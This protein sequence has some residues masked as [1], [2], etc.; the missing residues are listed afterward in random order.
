M[1]IPQSFIQDLLTRADIVDVVGKH[2]QLKKGGSNFMGLCPFHGEK[3]PSFSVSPSKQFY[4]CFGCG[5][6][7]NA[8]GFLMDHTGAGFVE[9]V[10]DLAQQMGLNVPEEQASPADRAQAAAKR[11]QHNSLGDFMSKAASS[12]QV[13]LKNTP[14]AVDYLKGRGLTGQIAKIFALGFAPEGWRHLA[15]V[16]PDYADKALVECGM[17]ITPDDDGNAEQ[18]PATAKRYDRFRDRIMFPIR[19]VK[20]EVIGF[21]GRV[22]DKGEPKYLNSP[23]TPLFSKGRELYGLFEGRT[24]MRERGYALVTEGYMDVVALAQMGFG[25]AVATLGTACTAD[26][27]HKLFRFTDNVVFGFDGDGA[28]RR[29]ARKALEAALP[30]AT[31]T[32]SVKFLFLP[33]EHD[34]D[35]FIRANGAQAFEDMVAKATPLSRFLV[36]AAGADLDLATAEGR[37]HMLS[38]AQPLWTALPD[39]ALKRQLL[40]ELAEASNLGS[41]EVLDVWQA[42]AKRYPTRKAAGASTQHSSNSGTSRGNSDGSQ[43]PPYSGAD[44]TYNNSYEPSNSYG[45]STFSRSPT[46]G[47][48][49]WQKSKPAY[50]SGRGHVTS[51]VDHVA[52]VVLTTP[53]A[54][55]WLST[56]EQHLLAEQDPPFGSLFTWLEAQWHDH[57]PQ[58]WA[59]LQMAMRDQSFAMQAARAVEQANTLGSEDAVETQAE[60]RELMRRMLI[61]HLQ[62]LENEAISQAETDPSALVRYR[63]LQARRVAL[64]GERKSMGDMPAT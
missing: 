48:R 62:L 5:K 46:Q 37:A 26:H 40:T 51:R 8:I 13:A 55:G 44:A 52:R 57:G 49:A 4:H 59:A 54:W 12:Y 21:G 18:D 61:E 9:A 20:G 16:F 23:E 1:A 25:N 19:N 15:N 27:M 24:A 41:H 42:N 63:D 10:Q 53:N 7:G 32:R 22:L 14:R 34:P 60:L 39:G 36:D 58:P 11:E 2:V 28:G 47:K 6:N 35:S 50:Q 29:A 43:S 31:D 17:V 33:A 56:E 30:Y 64:Q 38:A 45:T 3:S